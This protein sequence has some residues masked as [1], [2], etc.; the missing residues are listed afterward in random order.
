M[1]SFYSLLVF[2]LTVGVGVKNDDR[3]LALWSLLP[4]KFYGN[5]R[6]AD[7]NFVLINLYTVQNY[8]CKILFNMENICLCSYIYIILAGGLGILY[9]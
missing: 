9:K 6:C 1:V 4:S 3:I 5:A 8:V 7:T 2:K